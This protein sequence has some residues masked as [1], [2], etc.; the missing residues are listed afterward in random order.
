MKVM[1]ALLL[2][3]NLERQRLPGKVFIRPMVHVALAD[4]LV[5]P[6]PH[7]MTFVLPTGFL[8]DTAF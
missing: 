3:V 6:D 5:D 2:V 4:K 1:D 7:W 8:P